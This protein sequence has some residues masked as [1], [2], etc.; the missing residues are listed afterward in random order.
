MMPITGSSV[1]V[2]EIDSNL[3]NAF[4]SVLK[5]ASSPFAVT[6]GARHQIV[7]A[8]TAFRRLA[9][10]SYSGQN[11]SVTDVVLP[12][13]V[14][15]MQSLLD[16]ALAGVE[17]LHDRFL[18][19]LA[20]GTDLWS[21][22]IWPHGQVAQSPTGLVIELYRS[23]HPAP[24]LALQ[25]EVAERL[26]LTALHETDVAEHAGISLA[27]SEF[28]AEAGLRLGGSL[29]T[30]ATRQT[31]AGITLPILGAWCIV[32]LFESDGSISRLAMI[33]PD[34]HKQQ[35]LQELGGHWVPEPGDPF[36]APAIQSG[37][38]PLIVDNA[39]NAALEAAAHSPE[40]LR[41]LRELEITTLLTVPMVRRERLLG[42]VTFV[43]GKPGHAYSLDEI[44]LAQNLAAR[45][46]EALE[47]ARIYAEALAL[48]EQAEL[49]TLSKVRFLGNISHELRTPLNAILGYVEVIA[50]EIHGPVTPAQHRD[51]ERIRVN[52]EHIL[53]LVND[54]LT[55][56]RSGRPRGNEIIPMP[57]H[58]A[59][60]GAFALLERSLIP[61]SISYEPGTQDLDVV[62]LGDPERLRQILLNL[63][64]NAVKFTARGGHIS[65]RCEA[66]GDE[67][68]ISVAD[69][70][71]GIAP[72]Q[73]AV[74]FEPFVQVGS[75]QRTQG[76]F[77]LGLAI[78]REL[79][80]SM[81]GDLTVESKLGKGTCFTLTLP[82]AHARGSGY[83]PGE[84]M[85]LNSVDL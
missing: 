1:D 35:L 9:G 11:V 77:G 22:T 10:P 4:R 29:D 84:R 78:S 53:T 25:R 66:H 17:V 69:N 54:L 70:G 34:T 19:S 60:A 15:R 82:R 12:E 36:G 33:H 24:S 38:T 47:N 7:Y 46:A 65:T 3:D 49:A 59:V 32:D 63:I 64:A 21:C 57:A 45:N 37:S 31:V 26:L 40:N 27:Q 20:W 51:L 71:M 50:N 67:V 39:V 61:K 83:R 73:L 16:R 85:T 68:R 13:A 58:Q 56:V 30:T 23:A 75:K 43:S 74:I 52:Q 44:R 48:R 18:G 42:A 62:A 80:R 41:L 8:N 76:G 28:L 55:F 2:W 81:H 6:R 72:H 5:Y 14:M 79:A